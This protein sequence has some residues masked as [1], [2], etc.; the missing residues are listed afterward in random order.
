MV[1][2]INRIGQRAQRPALCH[3]EVQALRSK[4]RLVMMRSA[5]LAVNHWW[6]APRAPHYN[7][8]TRPTLP[9]LLFVRERPYPAMRCR[10]SAGRSPCS[11]D[12]PRSRRP[13]APPESTRL[14]LVRAA[15]PF[16]NTV[17]EWRVYVLP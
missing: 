16:A 10:E 2:G 13:P 6:S 8:K 17:A 1:V 7:E 14:S 11:S 5:Q 15:A 12:R 9:R 4:S 3:R